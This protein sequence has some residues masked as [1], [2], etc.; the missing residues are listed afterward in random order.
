MI[1]RLNKEGLVLALCVCDGVQGVGV[2][3][4]GRERH[5]RR[6]ME[7]S[8]ERCRSDCVG[9]LGNLPV[10]CDGDADRLIF[11]LLRE[12]VDRPATR[13]RNGRVGLED[14]GS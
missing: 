12:V 11:E 7:V 8:K 4:R 13:V 14:D 3:D 10:R 1:V 5:G 6:D 9:K 2:P